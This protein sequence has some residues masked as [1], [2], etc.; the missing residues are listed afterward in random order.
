MRVKALGVKEDETATFDR[1]DQGLSQFGVGQKARPQVFPEFYP[2]YRLW[3]RGGFCQGYR[4]RW[5]ASLRRNYITLAHSAF[6]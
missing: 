6:C 5:S 2:E 4:S 3:R 1:P